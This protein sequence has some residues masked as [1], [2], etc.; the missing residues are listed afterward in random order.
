MVMKESD[1]TKVRVYHGFLHEYFIRHIWHDYGILWAFLNLIWTTAIFVIL[2]QYEQGPVDAGALYCHCIILLPSCFFFGCL[3]WHDKCCSSITFTWGLCN[4]DGGSELI[5]CFSPLCV[6]VCMQHK[7]KLEK[8]RTQAEQMCTRLGRF[9]MPFA[10]TAI[11]L[12]NIVSSAGG[13]DRSDSDSDTGINQSQH[14]FCF[15]VYFLL[16]SYKF[17]PWRGPWNEH[18]QGIGIMFTTRA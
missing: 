18:A 10:W 1:S 7:E 5:H 14:T 9:R 16:I 13:I 6:C 11:H 4:P 2:F 8:L 15:K 12:L 3:K 17:S